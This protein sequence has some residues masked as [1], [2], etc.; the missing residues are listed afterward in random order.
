MEQEQWQ[1]RPTGRVSTAMAA[2]K[3]ERRGASGAG[4]EPYGQ[5]GENAGAKEGALWGQRGRKERL[6]G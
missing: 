3:H 6:P 5:T 1:P 2:R 4:N